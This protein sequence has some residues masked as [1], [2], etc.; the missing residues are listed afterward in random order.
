MIGS[1]IEG[2]VDF[3][4]MFLSKEVV[5]DTLS[6]SKIVEERT[7]LYMGQKKIEFGSYSMVNIF[8]TNTLRSRSVLEIS[9]KAS[10]NSSGYY[11]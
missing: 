5:S 8:T 11:L 7:K 4:D 9:L 1:P 6:P 2:T 10:N 3:L